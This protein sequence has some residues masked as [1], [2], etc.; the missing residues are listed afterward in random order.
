MIHRYRGGYLPA[1]AGL[2]PGSEELTT[3]CRR[4]SGL[5]QAALAR[6]G[7]RAA[8]AALWAIA[9]AANRPHGGRMPGSRAKVT[10]PEGSLRALAGAGPGVR[11]RA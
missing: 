4:S 1:A 10:E 6:F 8:T 3:A 2:A 5:I 7:F 9:E 11:L